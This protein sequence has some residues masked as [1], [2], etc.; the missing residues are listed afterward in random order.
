MHTKFYWEELEDAGCLQDPH[1][2][3]RQILNWITKYLHYMC[4]QF[5][6]LTTDV[7]IGRV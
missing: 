2:D 3:V 6:L 5:F 1:L 7:S 4:A